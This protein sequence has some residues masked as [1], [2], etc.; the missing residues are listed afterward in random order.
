MS[1]FF[2]A[3]HSRHR[4]AA[5]Q[6]HSDGSIDGYDRAKTFDASMVRVDSI[7][8]LRHGLDRLIT[9]SNVFIVRG[10]LI[11]RT[12]AN[13]IRRLSCDDPE[14]GDKA[15]LAEAP[16]CWIALDIDG[17]HRPAGLPPSD[18]LGCARC[19][20][21][22][23]PGEFRAARCIVQAS[24]SHGIK[25]GCHLRLWYWAQRPLL[26]RELSHW[27]RR[28]PVDHRLFV[29]AQPIFT[30]APVFVGC[31][32]HLSYRIIERAG[33]ETVETPS[34]AELDPIAIAPARPPRRSATE[35]IPHPTTAPKHSGNT[36]IAQIR[37]RLPPLETI[38]LSHGYDKNEQGFYRHPASQS[39]SYGA[40]IAN[41]GGVDR[42][43][44]LNAGDPLCA[45]NLPLLAC[46]AAPD[47]VD[48]TIILDHGGNR[49][50]GLHALALRFGLGDGRVST[51]PPPAND[52]DA[53]GSVKVREVAHA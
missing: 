47:A 48:V 45:A 42:V 35:R 28:A 44:S 36:L 19:A 49:S 5:K 29:T 9:R 20:I 53:Y 26:G 34:A 31:V 27:L 46:V 41:F 43:H 3:F 12:R 52:A 50:Q 37:Q 10:G 33:T 39:G 17:V 1:D 21:D 8:H 18:L 11:G 14:T 6:I 25:A 13:G 30:S 2:T 51:R 38:L 7:A 40:S 15:T 23:L 24:S 22:L 16:H 32:D 4:R